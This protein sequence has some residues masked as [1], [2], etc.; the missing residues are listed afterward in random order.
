MG[1]FESH[2]APIYLNYGSRLH[3][4]VILLFLVHALLRLPCRSSSLV[5]PGKPRYL[6]L[7]YKGEIAI[8]RIR[9]FHFGHNLILSATSWAVSQNCLPCVEVLLIILIK[10]PICCHA[11]FGI[12][13]QTVRLP[14]ALRLQNNVI[15]HLP[16]K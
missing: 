13:P 10:I 1:G 14:F 16:L 8:M 4:R 2:C 9:C 5:D 15:L 7:L 12:M 3:N 11:G 6:V